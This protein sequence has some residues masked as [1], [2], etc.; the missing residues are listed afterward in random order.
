MYYLWTY[1]FEIALTL[2]GI[3]L[4]TNILFPM[5][6]SSGFYTFLLCLFVI[7]FTLRKLSN[8]SNTMKKKVRQGGI[9]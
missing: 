8:I 3:L 4:G 7:A 2:I 6:I 5:F 9:L 1:K